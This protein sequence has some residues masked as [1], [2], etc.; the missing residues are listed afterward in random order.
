MPA[1]KRQTIPKKESD[2]PGVL[3][4]RKILKK[5]IFQ[6]EDGDE[7]SLFAAKLK[8]ARLDRLNLIDLEDGIKLLNSASHLYLQH[9]CM[10]EL[11]SK[12]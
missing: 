1:L 11:Q 7:E 9:V 5:H 6:K 3:T 8:R 4:L 12:N 2:P 10:F